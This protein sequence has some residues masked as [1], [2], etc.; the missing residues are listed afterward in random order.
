MIA[1]ITSA[2]KVIHSQTAPALSHWHRTLLYSHVHQENIAQQPLAQ[3][4]T[5]LA[6]QTPLQAG[7]MDFQEMLVTLNLTV[8]ALLIHVKA[9]S[10]KVYP[11]DFSAMIKAIARS[12][13]F[14]TMSHTD[15]KMQHARS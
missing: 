15:L 13:Y 1:I 4:V 11:R 5:L 3:L 12:V 9:I 14:A 2:T 7:P 6:C 8:E 10:A